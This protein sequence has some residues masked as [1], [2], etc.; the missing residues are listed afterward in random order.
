MT[1]EK[2]HDYYYYCRDLDDEKIVVSLQSVPCRALDRDRQVVTTALVHV[3]AACL[4][5]VVVVDEYVLPFFHPKRRLEPH[6]EVLSFLC[7]YQPTWTMA[8]LFRY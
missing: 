7:R 4:D 1:I 2:R 6:V 3:I 5:V 8:F